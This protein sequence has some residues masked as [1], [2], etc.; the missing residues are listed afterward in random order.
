LETVVPTSTPV[1]V[2]A[3]PTVT[4]SAITWSDIERSINDMTD[5]QRKDFLKTIKGVRVH[6][7]GL[8]KD[9]DTNG[10]ITLDMGQDMFISI[11]MKGVPKEIS[12]TLNKDQII[13]FE[14]TITAIYNFLGCIVDLNDPVLI[15][16]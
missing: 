12:K 2:V 16:K 8:V 6:W 7:R 13:E 5:I 10:T 14:A 9:V 1:P 3:I 11:F 15:H 4:P